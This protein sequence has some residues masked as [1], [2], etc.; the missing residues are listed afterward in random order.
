MDKTFVFRECT[1]E[2]N[3]TRSSYSTLREFYNDVRLMSEFEIFNSGTDACYK[4][5][6]VAF[7]VRN[8]FYYTFA[9][10]LF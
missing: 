6:V 7:I 10:D 3:F 1:G 9:L 8:A 2:R 4:L 5:D